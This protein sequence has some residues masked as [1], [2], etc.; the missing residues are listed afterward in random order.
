MRVVFFDRALAN[1]FRAEIAGAEIS[2]SV[3][4]ANN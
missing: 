1:V 3:T 4:I 2:E